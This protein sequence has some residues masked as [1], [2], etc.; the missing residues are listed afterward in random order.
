[1]TVVR[2][3]AKTKLDANRIKQLVEHHY[4]YQVYDIQKV[5]A[6]YKLETDHG[7]VAF[8]NAI[9]IK[10]ITFIDSIIQHLHMNGFSHVPTLR[11]TRFHELLVHDYSGDY[12][13]EQWLPS[14]VR[15]INPYQ[16]DWLYSAGKTIAQF[17]RTIS[18]YPFSYIPKPRIRQAWGEWFLKKYKK[19]RAMSRSNLAANSWFLARVE[20]AKEIFLSY[21]NLTAHLC[22]GSLHQENIMM[23]AK[24]DVWLIDF[25]R[26]THDTIGKD[27]AQVLMYHFRFHPWNQADV[28]Q[29][30]AGYQSVSK[31]S[32]ADLLHFCA[33][34]LIPDRMIYAYLDGKPAWTDDQQEW[35]KELVLREIV[36]DYWK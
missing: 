14:D 32:Q 6:V 19:L 13:V 18:T 30:L 21:P 33:R 16:R 28:E 31:L 15:E 17:H 8:K 11:K 4:G 24:S 35:E 29:L 20:Q 5:R 7:M 26:I 12:V 27:L 23:D 2:I 22:H 36:P 1:M 10:D 9:K 25:E 3:Q 34:N